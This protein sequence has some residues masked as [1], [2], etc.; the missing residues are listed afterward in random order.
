MANP[1]TFLAASV[2]RYLRQTKLGYLPLNS[3]IGTR[4]LTNGA[5]ATS[6]IYDVIMLPEREFQRMRLNIGL[7][8][9]ATPTLK[10]GGGFEAAFVPTDIKRV[11]VQPDDPE[12]LA[13]ARAY[14]VQEF[15]KDPSFSPSQPKRDQPEAAQDTPYWPVD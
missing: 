7:Q 10:M 11:L 14:L 8:H 5:G 2:P 12:P 3:V 6:L 15:A 9:V 13:T 1:K 4:V